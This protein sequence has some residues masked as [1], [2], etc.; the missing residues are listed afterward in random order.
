MKILLFNDNPVVRKLVALSAQKT[1]DDLIVIWSVDE[2]QESDYDLLIIDDALYSDEL[3]QSLKE[4][5]SFKATLLMAT[6]GKAVPAGFDNVINKPFLPTDLVDMFI[7]IDKK[8]MSV[9]IAPERVRS[10]EPFVK[11]E[12]PFAI[13]LDE[14]LPDMKEAGE[15]DSFDF[16]DLDDEIDL[17]ETLN[18]SDEIDSLEDFDD[19]VLPTAIL[20]KE[21]V[22]EV[23]NLLDDTESDDWNVEEEIIIKGIDEPDIHEDD[24][25][26]VADEPVVESAE[27]L[28]D[29]FLLEEEPFGEIESFEAKT[30]ET[31]GSAEEE[32]ELGD[33]DFDLDNEMLLPNLDDEMLLDDDE[34][35]DLETQIQDAVND[36]ESETLDKE[37]DLDDFKLDFDD[38]LSEEMDLDEKEMIDGDDL[39]GFDEL[40]MLDERELKLAIGEEVE[41][42]SEADDTEDDSFADVELLS[43][44]FEEPV[45][46][47]AENA[48]V[49]QPHTPSHAEGVEALQALLKAL[50]NEEVA[51][52]LKGLNISININFG[53]EQ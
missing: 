47:E 7:K 35:G 31:V 14:T 5:V 24:A 44:D 38:T 29:E 53:N 48:E 17:G 46:Y 25:L 34:L 22:Q 11:T 28:S 42:E 1:K 26:N 50:S 9:S 19:A 43:E 20:D 39:E 30:E 4:L 18:I 49:S 37:L 10:E 8:T 41:E 27:E 2:I 52:S 12:V 13:H 16:G 33:L 40:D 15:M 6:R 21:E 45:V 51:K 23:Q 36:L 3:F 32:S